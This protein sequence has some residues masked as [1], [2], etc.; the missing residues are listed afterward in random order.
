MVVH[1]VVMPVTGTESWTVLDD[2]GVPVVPIEVGLELTGSVEQ[3]HE[4][5]RIS[6]SAW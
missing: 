5:W 6:A 3:P 1:R 4:V 2:Q